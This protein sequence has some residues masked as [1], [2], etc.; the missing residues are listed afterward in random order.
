[1]IIFIFNDC[2][3]KFSKKQLQKFKIST[4]QNKIATII[5]FIKYEMREWESK[6]RQL[7]VD[8]KRNKRI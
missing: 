7:I 2:C 8:L 4:Y 5:A 3:W 1:M 6:K